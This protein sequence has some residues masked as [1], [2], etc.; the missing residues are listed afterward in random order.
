MW[1]ENPSNIT[2]AFFHY[3][4]ASVI[5]KKV[6]GLTSQPQRFFISSE[7]SNA[8]NYGLSIGN[9]PFTND[10]SV[11]SPMPPL[12]YAWGPQL[13]A[14]SVM[15]AYTD[16]DIKDINPD[17][18]RPKR[19][20]LLTANILA[21]FAALLFLVQNRKTLFANPAR[22]MAVSI[23]IFSFAQALVI[24]P[25][26]RFVITPMIFIWL[27]ACTQLFSCI[28]AKLRQPPVLS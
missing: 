26:Q 18:L 8:G 22:L 19:P 7:T 23:V 11:P 20:L 21:I 2:I 1:S 25:E 4:R 12:L 28:S 3:D 17:V 15:T 5:A 10:N 27:L 24:I 6:V 13:E 16:T 9:M 14:G